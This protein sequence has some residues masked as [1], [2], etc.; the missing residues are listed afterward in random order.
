LQSENITNWNKKLH[1]IFELILKEFYLIIKYNLKYTFIR[2]N[3][4]RKF[5]IKRVLISFKLI[6]YVFR[7]ITI[8]WIEKEIISTKIMKFV[9]NL[10]GKPVLKKTDTL[11]II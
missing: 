10:I 2:Y 6:K 1:K 7:T 5:F 9:N 11:H 4:E 3:S 8:Y